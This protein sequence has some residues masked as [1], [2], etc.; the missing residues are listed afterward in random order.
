MD[1]TAAA[2]SVALLLFVAG[3]TVWYM[4]EADPASG[5]C[6]QRVATRHHPAD[7]PAR[8][9]SHA[10]HAA[11]SAAAD[12]TGAA[13]APVAAKKPFDSRHYAWAKDVRAREAAVARL[14]VA[15]VASSAA[16]DARSVW[17]AAGT[18]E[19]RDVTA[20]AG[21]LLADALRSVALRGPHGTVAVTSLT[22]NAGT[23]SL[24]FVRGKIKPGYEW[25]V[26]AEW[27]LTAG[28]D[29][30]GDDGREPVGHL[31]RGVL[32][33]DGISDTEA[34]AFDTLRVEVV[35]VETDAL[36]HND[37][38]AAVVGQAELLREA[39]RSWARALAQSPA[40]LPVPS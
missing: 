32:H 6:R 12:D 37:A 2:V 35:A 22:R 33:L 21:P 39:V 28:G 7:P 3:V 9:A 5:E 8:S 10:L 16:A 11:V 19:E 36:T 29:S 1:S 31:A 34:D 18:W 23:A 40:A 14:G 24:A 17:N 38:K 15:P 26:T 4:M 27:A 25:A 30:R 13:T 20:K